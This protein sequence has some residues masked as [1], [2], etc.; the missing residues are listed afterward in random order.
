VSVAEAPFEFDSP[1]CIVLL[2]PSDV[3]EA[4]SLGRRVAIVTTVPPVVIGDEVTWNVC[5]LLPAITV[6]D[7]GTVTIVLFEV[8]SIGAACTAAGPFNVTVPVVLLPETTVEGFSERDET[9]GAIITKD[10]EPVDAPK[11]AVI[12][13]DWFAGTGLVVT[14]TL[15]DR[16]PGGK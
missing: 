9:T 16:V 10:P 4:A 1:I 12:C 3:L 8:R 2:V 13:A 5:W 7:A 15:T 11:V 14:V 6:T